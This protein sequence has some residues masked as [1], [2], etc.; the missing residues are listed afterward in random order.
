MIVRRIK[1]ENFLQRTEIQKEGTIT[2]GLSNKVQGL[3]LKIYRRHYAGPKGL[4]HSFEYGLRSCLLLRL[5]LIKGKENSPVS[6]VC[7]TKL[8]F[9]PDVYPLC[10][11]VL[12]PCRETRR[13]VKGVTDDTP[14]GGVSV[15]LPLHFL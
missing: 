8:K 6:F 9:N 15:T 14:D 5:L 2:N 7:S 13:L 3:D 12:S 4:G 10:P 11:C 1:R